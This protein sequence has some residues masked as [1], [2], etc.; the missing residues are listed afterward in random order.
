MGRSARGVRG[1]DLQK[2]DE[3]V[4]M[5]IVM[6]NSTIM[7]V[8]ENGFG[9]RTGLSEYRLQGRGGKGI[10]T[11]KTTDKTGN[12]VGI[13][14]V[15]DD[16]EIMM[17][18]ANGKVIRLKV[19]SLRTIGRNTQGVKLFDIEKGDKIMAVA[20]LAEKEEEAGEGE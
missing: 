13:L 17:I 19:K 3:V 9:K 6:D 10:I 12:V 2:G 15:A 5:E 4:G 11:L 20:L 1:I 14:Q 16:D 8:A 18:T 7:T